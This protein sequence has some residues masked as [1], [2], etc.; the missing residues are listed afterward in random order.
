MH[1]HRAETESRLRRTLRSRL[2]PAIYRPLDVPLT[3]EA[4]HAPGEP[5][6]FAE[7][8]NQPFAPAAVGDA[9]GRPWSTSWFHI[10]GSVP[11]RLSQ[12]A[13]A[14][15][16]QVELVIDLGFLGG[17]GFTSEGLLYLPNGTAVKGIHPLT[18]Y[19]TLAPGQS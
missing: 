10:T 5:V 6:P 4:W 3:I 11:R 2:I 16:D 14:A 12:Q 9:W 7:A 15:G 17:P 1:D 8:V 19:L 13:K 18:N